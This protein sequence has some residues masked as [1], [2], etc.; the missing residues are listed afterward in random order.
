MSISGPDVHRM[1]MTGY[2]DAQQRLESARAT[3]GQTKEQRDELDDNRGEALVDLAEHYLP[4]LTRD[5][6]R[7]TWDEIRAT[8]SQILL[9]K[10]EHRQK[11]RESLDRLNLN[12]EHEE[13]QLVDIT[14]RLDAA[15]DEQQKVAD[16]VEDVLREDQQFVGL[17]DRAAEA[18]AALERAEAN[19]QEIEQ[20]AALKLPAYDNNKLFRYLYDQGFGT[21][22]YSKRGFTRR[23]DRSVAK[24]INYVKA[25]Q[26][27]EF[28]KTTPSQMRKIIAQDRQ[29][30]E[31]VMLE[32]ERRRDQV[33]AE[34][35]LPSKIEQ[36]E[37]LFTQRTE[38]IAV[39]DQL[40]QQTRGIERELTELE[41][42]R[43]PYYREAISLFRKML[44]QSDTRDLARRARTT[45]EITDDQIV[46]K[47]SGVDAE[48]Q[49]LDQTARRR[50]DELDDMQ[51]Y[52]E[53][54]GRLIQRFRSSQFDSSR[55]EFATS[56]DVAGGLQRARNRRD[57]EDFWETIRRAQRWGPTAVEQIT[58]VASHPLT[59]ILIN[60]M[61]HAAGGALQNHARRAGRRHSRKS[62]WDGW[63]SSSG[64]FFRRR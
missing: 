54:L 49:Q 56:L 33:A 42:T 32:L 2:T 51:E 26:G 50:R 1:L 8:V 47:L 58:A 4:E 61:A 41:G 53:A 13:S 18:E 44:E 22:Q 20:D 55:S 48:I 59:Q 9:R 45:R 12:R 38:Q 10:E 25:R 16:Q 17:S 60:A 62:S 63:G 15:S 11:L 39:L 52:L 31:T 24:F 6:I 3:I 14:Q 43:G 36:T 34:L 21:A 40:Q 28:L 19:L 46:A 35:N 37:K 64:D 29:S 30:F 5:A 7:S 27:Y 57:I 23:M